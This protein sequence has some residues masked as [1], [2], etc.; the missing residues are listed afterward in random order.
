[1][2]APP[3]VDIKILTW[4]LMFIESITQ[5]GEKWYNSGLAKNFEAFQWLI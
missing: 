3:I 4:V 2:I 5:V 1:M